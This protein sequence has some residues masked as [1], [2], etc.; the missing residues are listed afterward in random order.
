MIYNQTD[1]DCDFLNH[2]SHYNPF[3]CDD[4]DDNLYFEDDIEN[5]CDTLATSSLLLERCK[6]MNQ[7]TFN[8]N[9]NSTKFSN[10]YISIF[11]HNIDGFKSNFYEFLNQNINFSR[12]FDFYCFVETNLKENVPNDFNINDLYIHE[13]FYA[14][15]N[16]HKGSGISIYYKRNINFTRIKKLCVRNQYFEC[17]GGRIETDDFQYYIIVLYRF[18]NNK[19]L[20]GLLGE[21]S[22]LLDGVSN[23]RCF[24]LGDFNFNL[25]NFN[26]NNYVARY[27]ELFF[28]SGFAPLISK[29]T[30]VFKSSIT[31]IDQIWCNFVDESLYSGVIDISVSNH[32]PLFFMFPDE[33]SCF[34]ASLDSRENHKK[35]I[36]HNISSKNIEKF[37][38]KF[39][40]Y[41]DQHYNM[42]MSN[43]F[44]S[45]PEV[46]ENNF[47]NFLLILKLFMMILYWRRLISAI[48]EILLKNRGLH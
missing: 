9:F 47:T 44:T 23:N 41:F 15:E 31:L 48:I 37:S 12:D 21:L 22:N 36:A 46:A 20:E 33:T 26:N 38:L 27:S 42:F 19:N 45:D 13:Q 34:D 2:Y 39:N 16:K 30:H 10:N 35:Y 4:N 7:T 43:N 29:P 18:N 28:T 14:I 40:T 6:V 24:I 3:L 8:S 11:Y 5:I 32:K 1:V 17:M 25:F